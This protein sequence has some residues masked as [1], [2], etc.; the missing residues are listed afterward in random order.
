MDVQ[1]E[2][3]RGG[4]KERSVA[5]GKQAALQKQLQDLQRSYQVPDACSL[6]ALI[7]VACYHASYGQMLCPFVITQVGEVH[8]HAV[9]IWLLIYHSGLDQAL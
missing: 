6:F 9:S 1:L 8:K 5:V 7:A 4:F 2:E 3:G